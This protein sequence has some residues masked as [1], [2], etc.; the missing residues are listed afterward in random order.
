M[1]HIPA[2]EERLIEES[3]ATLCGHPLCHRLLADGQ[4]YSIEVR[5]GDESAKVPAG[6]D[7]LFAATAYTAIARGAVTPCTLADVMADLTKEWRGA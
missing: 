5:L 7:L 6:A 3:G 1:A 4:G 2:K